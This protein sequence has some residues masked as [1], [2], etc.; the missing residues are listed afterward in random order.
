MNTNP[1]ASKCNTQSVKNN[2]TAIWAHIFM[3]ADG[4][5]YLPYGAGFEPR[6]VHHVKRRAC[7]WTLNDM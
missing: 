5:N 6:K 7:T 4:S 1:H 2:D 3:A